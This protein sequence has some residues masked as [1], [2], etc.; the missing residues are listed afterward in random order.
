MKASPKL[1]GLLLIILFAT[2]Y[3][4]KAQENWQIYKPDDDSFSV[5]LPCQ[6]ETGLKN[7]LTDVGILEVKTV[8]CQADD[9]HPNRLYLINYTDYPEG[10][11][12][13]DSSELIQEFFDIT[14]AQH[15]RDLNGEVIY[16]AENNLGKYPGRIYRAVY[17][18]G[19]TFVK[20][21]IYLVNDRFYSI[22]VY[23]L[24]PRSINNAMD[25]FINSFKILKE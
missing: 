12:H 11:F 7:L 20:S 6:A 4:L 5:L 2:L 22:Q 1:P 14:I 10:S 8:M 16:Q 21:V 23:A 15:V 25:T 17:N 13:P 19:N 9:D 3:E 24:L 18:K